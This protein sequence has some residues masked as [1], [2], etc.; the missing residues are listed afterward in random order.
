MRLGHVSV[1]GGERDAIA[2]NACAQIPPLIVSVPYHRKSR[3][4]RLRVAQAIAAADEAVREKARVRAAI[5]VRGPPIGALG[6]REV[7]LGVAGR[8]GS[9]NGPVIPQMHVRMRTAITAGEI[10][11]LP[12]IGAEDWLTVWNREISCP[13]AAS[14]CREKERSGKLRPGASTPEG[15]SLKPSLFKGAGPTYQWSTHTPLVP[16]KRLISEI[17]E[18]PRLWPI[19]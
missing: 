18:P 1:V 13:C 4:D 15:K 7:G 17:S 12:L 19:M 5:L 2:D 14:S 8:S 10:G 3:A 16:S 9:V 6:A 11:K